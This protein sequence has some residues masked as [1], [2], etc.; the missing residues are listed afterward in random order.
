MPVEVKYFRA[1]VEATATI[2]PADEDQVYGTWPRT[3]DLGFAIKDLGTND[4]QVKVQN[5]AN[6]SWADQVGMKAGD[7]LLQLNKSAVESSQQLEAKL[8]TFHWGD[9]FVLVVKRDSGTMLVGGTLPKSR[10][11]A[12]A[13]LQK[14]A[15][16][17]RNAISSADIV[18]E[19]DKIRQGPHELM[20]PA[21]A[22][23]GGIGIPSL[24][25]ENETEY[26]LT[27]LLSG[28]NSQKVQISP[29]ASKSVLIVPGGYEIAARVSDPSVVPFYGRQ[30]FAPGS[31]Y[32]EHFYISMG[33]R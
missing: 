13:S 2:I 12:L 24:V 20:P 11:V 14:P 23:P 4:I 5:V 28:P 9:D 33:P 1:G 15:P 27:I 25:V 21:Q 22:I 3:E 29:G 32:S 10:S 19:I 16:S 31:D 8:S 17:S 30:P 6:G 26:T 7:F 18:S